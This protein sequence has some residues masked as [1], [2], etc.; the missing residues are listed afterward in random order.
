MRGVVMLTPDEIERYDR[1]IMMAEIG[2][3]GQEK[4]KRSKVLIAGA[5]GLGSSASF[6]LA[7]SSI[8][9]ELY[10]LIQV[11]QAFTWKKQGQS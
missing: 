1:Q 2:V 4:L 8:S 6:Y 11:P 3:E 7:Q 9:S 5:G 10:R